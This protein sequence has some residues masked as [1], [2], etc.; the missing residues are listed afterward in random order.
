VHRGA[1]F[2]D[3]HDVLNTPVTV[4]ACSYS[5]S[6]PSFDQDGNGPKRRLGA[7]MNSSLQ[8]FGA[9]LILAVV[10]VYLILVAQ[11]RSFVDPFVILLAVPPRLAGALCILILTGTTLNV[12]T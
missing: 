8:S 7:A 4:L 3:H 12:S 2:S 6:P 5:T 11:F 10:L 1:P 9:G